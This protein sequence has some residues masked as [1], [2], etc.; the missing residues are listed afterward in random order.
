MPLRVWRHDTVTPLTAHPSDP[1]SGDVMSNRTSTDEADTLDAVL[2]RW[3]AAVDAHQPEHVAALFT[4][5]AIFQGLHPYTVGQAGVAE[6][7]AAQP[8]GMTA[9]VIV[10]T[11]G[12]GCRLA[13]RGGRIEGCFVTPSP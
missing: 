7:Y 13:L 11:C 3:K 4:T 10:K 12:W 1:G 9:G 2:T 5:D 6:Y 8:T